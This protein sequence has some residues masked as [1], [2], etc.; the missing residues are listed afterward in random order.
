MKTIHI[1]GH[2][3][4]YQVTGQ[5]PPLVLLHNAGADHRNWDGQTAFFQDRYTVYALDLPGYGA[6]AT[7]GPQTL[8]LHASSLA[9][10][11]RQLDLRDVRLVGHCVGGAA[12]WTCAAEQH[13]R[14]AVLVLFSPATLRTVQGGRYGPLHRICKRSPLLHRGLF[15]TTRLATGLAPLRRASVAS[16]FGTDAPRAYV[17]RAQK[18][19]GRIDNLRALDDLLLRLESFAPLDSFQRPPGFPPT[20][21]V[22]GDHNRVLPIAAQPAI[23]ALLR[24][25]R[26]VTLPKR[27]HLCMVEAPQEVNALMQ[28]FFE[29]QAP[30]PCARKRQSEPSG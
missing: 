18:R 28:A 19:L 16:M 9:A 2:P 13:S 17:E 15:H 1:K 6:S 27:G 4:R 23:E 5:G 14:I 12:A 30:L 20:C 10:V 26:S 24:P 25:E 21:L 8:D 22:W 3:L 29:E 11:L 7:A